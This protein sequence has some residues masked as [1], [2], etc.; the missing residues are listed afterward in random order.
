[1]KTLTLTKRTKKLLH[2]DLRIHDEI[3]MEFTQEV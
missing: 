3:T 2:S 1:M